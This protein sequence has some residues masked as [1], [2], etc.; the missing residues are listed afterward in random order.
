MAYKLRECPFCH[1]KMV[2][3]AVHDSEGTIMG[4][5]VA[6]MNMSHGAV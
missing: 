6:T 4:N 1:Q 2:Y 3:I 5:S